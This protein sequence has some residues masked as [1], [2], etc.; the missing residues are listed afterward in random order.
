MKVEYHQLDDERAHKIPYSP[1][2]SVQVGDA[3]FLYL[4]GMTALPLFHSHPHVKEETMLPDDIREQTARVMDKLEYI[5][6]TQG[7]TFSDVIKITK[8]LTDFREANDIREVMEERLGDTKPV[9]TTV[10]IN[11]LSSHG[12]RLEVDVTAVVQA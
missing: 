3:R 1:V 11:N 12:A 6:G 5:L 2:V 4:S 8:Y 7:A 10:A 9:S